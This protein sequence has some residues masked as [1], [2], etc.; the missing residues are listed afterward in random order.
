MITFVVDASVVLK[1]I[2]DEEG[3]EEARALSR[4]NLVAPPLMCLEVLN[5]AARKWQ[6]PED[7]LFELV[8]AL[9]TSGVLIDEP[10]LVGVARWAAQGLSAYDAAYVALAEAHECKL[11]TADADILALAPKVAIPLIA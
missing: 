3:S 10:P 7:A 6:W 4:E 2:R 5:I 1:W 9:E 8:R 11:V